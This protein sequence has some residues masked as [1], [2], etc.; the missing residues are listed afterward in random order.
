M[1][2]VMFPSF[3]VCPSSTFADDSLSPAVIKARLP[4]YRLQSSKRTCLLY[5]FHSVQIIMG[6]DLV[7]SQ[8]KK[9]KKTDRKFPL[10]KMLKTT[11]SLIRYRDA[12]RKLMEDVYVKITA[13]ALKW[14][15][16]LVVLP[17]VRLINRSLSTLH[18]RTSTREDQGLPN[19]N[20]SA[21]GK[22]KG[23]RERERQNDGPCLKECE[24]F[25]LLHRCS[26][27]HECT[28]FYSKTNSL[29]EEKCA[30]KADRRIF[31]SLSAARRR[32]FV[33]SRHPW[34][35][36]A[37]QVEQVRVLS[38]RSSAHRLV[39]AFAGTHSAPSRDEPCFCFSYNWFCPFETKMDDSYWKIRRST[40]TLFLSVFTQEG[41]AELCERGKLSSPP[42]IIV[43]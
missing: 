42:R 23:K 30:A 4:L 12:L 21:Q 33:D 37:D 22:R 31:I 2:K 25:C 13:S 17:H 7:F 39:L 20:W 26:L 40:S 16:T 41:N 3:S 9:K 11:R 10:L 32:R 34:I 19:S 6:V 14:N 24:D 5:S 43:F 36:P 15:G 18:Q 28:C 35:T 38:F 1:G 27:T 8:W 29:R